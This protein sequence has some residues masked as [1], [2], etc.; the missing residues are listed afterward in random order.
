MGERS[1]PHRKTGRIRLISINIGY[2]EGNSPFVHR[3]AQSSSSPPTV[4]TLL[5]RASAAAPRPR[6]CST[7][8]RSLLSRILHMG[9]GG[10]GFGC[11]LRLL[12]PYCTSG[13]AAAREHIAVEVEVRMEPLA[14]GAGRAKSG[15]R[16]NGFSRIA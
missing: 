15:G 3:C 16:P 14:K 8:P 13:A 2:G 9:R 11:R 10:G 4:G 5:T 12:P 7:S 1:L 6:E